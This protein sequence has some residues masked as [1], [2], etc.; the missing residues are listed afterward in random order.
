M[1][2][3]VLIRSANATLQNQTP[4]EAWSGSKSDVSD[5]KNWFFSNDACSKGKT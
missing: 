1:A 4:E 2:A 3:F 5:L